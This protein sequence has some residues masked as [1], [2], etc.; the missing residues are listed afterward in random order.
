MS[1][2]WVAIKQYWSRSIPG[3]WNVILEINGVIHEVRGISPVD[4][5]GKVKKLYRSQ[6][7]EISDDVI[8]GTLN[9]Y[10]CSKAPDRCDLAKIPADSTITKR[11]VESGGCNTCGTASTV[12]DVIDPLKVGVDMR[13]NLTPDFWGPIIWRALNMFG[14]LFIKSAFMEYVK[15]IEAFLDPDNKM[16]HGS[17]CITC[18]MEFKALLL[19]NPP[20]AVNSAQ[21]ASA[22]VLK[23]H[24]SV[25]T[26]TGK[27]EYD[28]QR[29]RREYGVV[30]SDAKTEI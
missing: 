29:F 22:W 8:K 23:L 13:R 17:G 5:F 15:W 18:F 11:L 9:A 10:W 16:N 3:G 24:N 6:K 30:T 4:L 20:S 21:Q 2:A 26:R 1:E 28:M 27:Q 7:V 19:A 12:V 25:N 14:V